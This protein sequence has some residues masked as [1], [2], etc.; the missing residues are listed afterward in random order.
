[1]ETALMRHDPHLDLLF[2]AHLLC[3]VCQQVPWTQTGRWCDALLCA[4]CASGEPDPR[5]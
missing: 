1:M 4:A 3:E 2:G 5:D